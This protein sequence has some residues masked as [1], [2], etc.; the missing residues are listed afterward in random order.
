MKWNANNIIDFLK[1]YEKY[2]LLWNM[3]HKDHSNIKSRNELFKQLYEQL[4]AIG[5]LEGVDEKQ[6]KSRIKTIKDV[7]RQELGKI[8]RSRESGAGTEVYSPKLIWFNSAYFLREVLS[9]RKS[10]SNLDHPYVN[11]EKEADEAQELC[12]VEGASR[13]FQDEN[14]CAEGASTRVSEKS[15]T[16]THIEMRPSTTRKGFKRRAASGIA[17]AIQQIALKAAEDRPYD[18]FGKYVAAELRSLPQRQAILLQ[19]EIQ[20]SIT[21]TKLSCLEPMD[22]SSVQ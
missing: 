9:T 19:L 13:G 15:P 6:L 21:H 7:Y 4:D 17:F 16:K 2:P 11:Q 14:V 12:E 22:H 3:K 18:Q 1:I 8:E 20:N 5:L 10:K